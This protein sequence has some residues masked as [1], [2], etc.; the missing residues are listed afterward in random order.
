MTHRP[1]P[2]LPDLRAPPPARMRAEIDAAL[3]DSGGQVWRALPGGRVNR[4]W[5]RG[6]VVAKLY[7][8]GGA[9]PLFPNDPGAEARAL[10]ALAPL[11]LA[12]VL[13][14]EGAGWIAYR[15][16]PGRSWRSGV[17]GVAHLLA[18]IHARPGDGFRDLPSGSAAILAQG[19]AIAADC[20]G[21]LPPPPP[22]P[23]VPPHPRPVLIHADPVPGNL[24]LDPQGA[25]TAIDWQC[26]ARGDP[27]EDLA[28]FLSPAMQSLY[29]GR[30]LGT[31]A[32]RA[33]LAAYP[34]AQTVARTRVLLPLF[35][36]RMAAHCLWKAERGAP[37]YAEALALELQPELTPG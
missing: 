27:A 25:L 30:P 28:A 22:D 6:D 19:A 2:A 1:A 33:F 18:R 9:S 16:L 3:G 37:G 15:H 14:A 8:P 13:L 24:I 29:R 12:P 17:A 32:A 5:R 31:L 35:R 20:R 34:C 4:L 7:L 26:P 21:T 23:G 10:R 36:W 11:G